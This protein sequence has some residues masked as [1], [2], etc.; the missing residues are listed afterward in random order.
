MDENE[1][2]KTILWTNHGGQRGRERTNSR[3][4]D[5]RLGC[6]NWRVDV[7]DR[8]RWLHVLGGQG[9]PRVVEPIMTMMMI[10]QITVKGPVFEPVGME[11]FSYRIIHCV[12]I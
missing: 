5:G 10:S 4:I 6:R 8:G 7:Q 11:Y 9:P 1:L 3:W 2:P 12:N